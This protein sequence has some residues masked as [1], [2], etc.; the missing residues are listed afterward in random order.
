SSLHRA[1]PRGG[2]RDPGLVSTHADPPPWRN[3]TR[4]RHG[5]ALATN[6]LTRS[7]L[8]KGYRCIEAYAPSSV[9]PRLRPTLIQ[10]TSRL[11]Q[12]LEELDETH[13]IMPTRC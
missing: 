2:A 10:L 4:A 12:I 8:S 1:L 9:R 6:V 11:T 7:I 13:A 5:G 3:P